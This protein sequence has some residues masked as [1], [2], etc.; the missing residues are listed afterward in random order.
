M[1]VSPGVVLRLA[2]LGLV[3]V[4]VQLSAV[5][6]VT[7][8]GVTADL[9][10]LIVMSTGL[11]LGSVPGAVMGFSMGL[12]VDMAL[13][14][15][16]GVSSLIFIA[17]GYGAGRL[18]ELRD[19]AHGLIP[20]AAGAAATAI[21]EV[22][23]SMIQFLLGVEAPVSLLL[24]RQILA[25]IVL[26]TL[27]A[28][29]IYAL[30]R[31]IVSNYLPDDPRRRRRRA[32]TTGG[33]SPALALL[34]ALMITSPE[35][36]RPPITPQLAVRV[37]ILGGVA[38][39]LFAIIFFRLWFLQVLSGDQY[40]AQARNNQVRNVK[41]EA[42]RGDIVDRNGT[43]LVK[44][45][46]GIAV[47]IDPQRVP[48]SERDLAAA[49]GSQL[50][51][52]ERARIAAHAER[53]RP[54]AIP[55]VAASDVKLGRLYRRLGRTIGM[56]PTTIH[57]EVITQLAMT[58]YSSVTIKTDVPFTVYSHIREHQRL[59]PGVRV[60]EVFL[61]S[62]PHD[63]LAAQLFGTVGEI[64]PDEL[65]ETHFRGV[66]QGTRVGKG[67]IEYAYDRYLRGDDGATRVQVDALGRPK[68]ELSVKNA[69]PGKQLKL[70][71][72]L[73]LQAEGQ[74]AV[75]KALGLAHQNGF[76]GT[77]G[78]FVAMDP[79]NGEVLA[80]G[81]YP[82][83]DPNVFAKPLTQAKFDSIRNAPGSP[84]YNRALSGLYPTGSTFKPITALASLKPG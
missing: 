64:S 23:F 21:T 57:R 17:V 67:G 10:P 34:D 43:V 49:Y 20:L 66:D 8:I 77:A 18:R 59:F 55:A 52:S 58:P 73:G 15:T 35:D 50:A 40:L 65:K 84:L 13:L 46:R 29:P 24:V 32:Y 72:D 44:S 37:A 36:R 53:A 54:V 79:R 11:L 31:A 82:S 26:N 68:G 48:V 63:S 16:P 3:A 81:S 75:A 74:R 56:S 27:L 2:A 38:F 14:Q 41:V 76:A 78:G 33:L 30:V 47:Q 7:V 12:L 9:S 60:Q 22:G 83:F 28:L 61:R 70:S 39:A 42:P 51:A 25:T 4:I 80:M 62:Y 1:T 5:S 69:V 45:R 71:I 19:P 6:Q